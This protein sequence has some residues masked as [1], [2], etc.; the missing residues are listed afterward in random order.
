MGTEDLIGAELDAAVARA[1][2]EKD[3]DIEHAGKRVFCSVLRSHRSDSFWTEFS[4]STNWNQG[5]PLIQ[6]HR[7]D[8]QY[9]YPDDPY[10][11]EAWVAFMFF[12][13]DRI[14]YPGPTPLIAAMRA[15]VAS[16]K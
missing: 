16:K 3:V 15:F 10:D 2:G 12:G 13:K 11:P 1:M 4:P 9:D 5:G 6:E 14:M 8:V 7:I